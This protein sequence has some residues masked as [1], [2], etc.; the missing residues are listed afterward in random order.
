[1]CGPS[2]SRSEINQSDLQPAWVIASRHGGAGGL[3]GAR[4]LWLYPCGARQNDLCSG[5]CLWARRFRRA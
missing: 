5:D 3:R 4:A 1:M 2:P